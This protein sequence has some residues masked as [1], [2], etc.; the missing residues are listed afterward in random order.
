MAEMASSEFNYETKKLEFTLDISKH[1]FVIQE[2][3]EELKLEV[4]FALSFHSRLIDLREDLKWGALH[5]EVKVGYKRMMQ[6]TEKAKEIK[7]FLKNTNRD[8]PNRDFK[9]PIP[10][11]Q[12]ICLHLGISELLMELLFFMRKNRNGELGIKDNEVQKGPEIFA[13]KPNEL[14]KFI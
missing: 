4:L 13:S 8:D 10:K 11:R 5:S 14:E 6:I 12:V 7:Y 3:D 9:R 1:C 2:I